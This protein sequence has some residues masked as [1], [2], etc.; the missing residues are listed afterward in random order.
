MLVALLLQTCY[1]S[2]KLYTYCKSCKCIIH[3]VNATMLA[4]SGKCNSGSRIAERKAPP[5]AGAEGVEGG[6]EARVQGKLSPKMISSLSLSLSLSL[7]QGCLKRGQRQSPTGS[8][9]VWAG[10][11]PCDQTT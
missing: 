5:G 10:N 9:D 4:T 11:R 1:T 8:T 7:A 3:N 2:I 6:E